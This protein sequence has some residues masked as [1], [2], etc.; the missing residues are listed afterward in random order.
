MVTEPKPV[1]DVEYCESNMVLRCPVCTN[2]ACTECATFKLSII[3]RYLKANFIISCPFC[4]SDLKIVKLKQLLKNSGGIPIKGIRENQ[5]VEI[6]LTQNCFGKEYIRVNG[7]EDKPPETRLVAH[8][9]VGIGF[10]GLS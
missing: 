10:E 2:G 7:I 6:F 4:R 9:G 3:K 5:P 1:C 8:N